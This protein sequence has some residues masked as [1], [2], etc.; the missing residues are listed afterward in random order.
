[1]KWWSLA[2]RTSHHLEVALLAIWTHGVDTTL[3]SNEQVQTSGQV[4]L[5]R[6]RILGALCE[7][8]YEP[9]FVL[10]F[11]FHMGTEVLMF[12]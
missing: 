2:E 11:R 10:H 9:L 5:P 4:E 3:V 12:C 8:A 7:D 1:M 6:F